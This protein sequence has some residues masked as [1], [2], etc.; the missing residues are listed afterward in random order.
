MAGDYL[1]GDALSAADLALYPLV[2]LSLRMDIRK[3]GLDAAGIYGPKLH[4]WMK[5]IESLPYFDRTIPP[6]WKK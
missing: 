6:H 5:R 4:A 1:D 3:P 2:A